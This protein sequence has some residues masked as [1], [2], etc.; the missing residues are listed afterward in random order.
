L[1]RFTHFSY[2]LDSA[3]L[4]ET[5]P[6]LTGA[7]FGISKA[8]EMPT[9]YQSSIHSAVCIILNCLELDNLWCIGNKTPE[10]I[11]FLREISG[12]AA[13]PLQGVQPTV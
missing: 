13:R 8:S 6:Q 12:A 1:L 4:I 10:I 7:A 5:P 2:F 11:G 9:T 3:V